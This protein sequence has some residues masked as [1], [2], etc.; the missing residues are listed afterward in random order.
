MGKAI[1]IGLVIVIVAL[2]IAG[3]TVY[4]RRRAGKEKALEHGWAIKGDLNRRQEQAIIA[5][6]NTADIL[7]R[8]LLAPPG[9]LTGDMTLLRMSDRVKV[10]DWLLKRARNDNRS[11][12]RRAIDNS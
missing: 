5:E 8:E 2:I 3:V 10:Q 4:Y 7:F 11:D 9:D 6:L 12:T 1:I